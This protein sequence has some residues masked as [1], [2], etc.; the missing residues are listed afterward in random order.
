MSW[1]AV[2]DMA[3]KERSMKRIT[4]LNFGICAVGMMASLAMAGYAQDQ[5]SQ[6]SAQGAPPDTGAPARTRVGGDNAEGYL[7]SEVQ[8]VYPLLARQEGIEGDV[9]L[10]VV[11]GTDGAVKKLSVISGHPLLIQAAIDAVRQ[12][13][14]TPPLRNG[15]P[16]EVK[17]KITVAF[18]LDDSAPA[19]Q[20]A[21]AEGAPADSS[22]GG[23]GAAIDP[24]LKADI[25]HLFDVMNLRK[26]EADTSKAMAGPLRLMVLP[27]LPDTPSKDKIADEFVA[28]LVVKL[29]SDEAMDAFA[30]VYAKYFSD[31][32]VKALTA[33]YGTPAGQHYNAIS[34][35]LIAESEQVGEKIGQESGPGILLELC[36]EYPELRG[37]ASFCAKTVP[38]SVNQG[39]LGGAGLSGGER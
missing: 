8:P 3:E 14:Y 18:Q 27:V 12:W 19:Q 2:E 9:V 22:S 33:F 21:P 15:K 32:D 37:Q 13:K 35:Q 10:R 38:G 25:M 17:T 36:D 5:S 11:V 39:L 16:V 23:T 26:T 30:V 6:A 31:D 28:K 34:G 29:Q 1:N 20:T 4:R 24:Q 7:V